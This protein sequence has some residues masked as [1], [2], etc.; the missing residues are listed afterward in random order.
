MFDSVSTV[1]Y[2]TESATYELEP[3]LLYRTDADD[4]S[5]RQFG[6]ASQEELTSYLQGLLGKAVTSRADAAERIPAV[7]QVLSLC[8]CNYDE[9]DSGRTILV[10][11][12]KGGAQ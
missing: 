12:P 2:V 5:V 8:T 3:L 9:G 10:C 1:W 7:T 4:A 11:V 6:F